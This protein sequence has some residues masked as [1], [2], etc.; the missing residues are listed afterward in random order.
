MWLATDSVLSVFVTDPETI[1]VASLPLKMVGWF[2][3]FDGVGLILM[4]ALLGVGAAKVVM[5][6]SIGFQWGLFLPVA[7][8]VGPWL[9]GGL[10]AVWIAQFG[11]RALQAILFGHLWQKAEWQHIKV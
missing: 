4:N 1:A 9:G 6:A 8:I 11:Y 5:K 10:I 3:A 2:I 7:W